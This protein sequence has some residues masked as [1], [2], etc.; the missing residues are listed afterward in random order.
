[1]VRHRLVRVA[2]DIKEMQNYGMYKQRKVHF[3]KLLQSFIRKRK[4]YRIRSEFGALFQ[5]SN[6]VTHTNS[7]TQSCTELKMGSITEVW[8]NAIEWQK[9]FDYLDNQNEGMDS[10]GIPL[11]LSR[12]AKFLSLYVN[13]HYKEVQLKSE[14]KPTG[15]SL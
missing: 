11:K 1:M 5:N 10:S 3:F 12:Y 13:L 6:N 9:F 4:S 7:F 2:C 14:N 8:K 15:V